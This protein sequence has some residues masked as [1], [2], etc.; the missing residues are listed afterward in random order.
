[1]RISANHLA[2]TI[3]AFSAGAIL[4]LT[5]LTVEVIE[6]N[7]EF[8]RKIRIIND[9]TTKISSISNA[10]S[11][12]SSAANS[13]YTRL[14]STSQKLLNNAQKK[15]SEEKWLRLSN[16]IKRAHTSLES[17]S[18]AYRSE[19]TS[20]Y[21][22]RLRTQT[23]LQIS[24]SLEQLQ[25]LST[26]L[27]S[28]NFIYK[29]LLLQ[30]VVTIS[31][32]LLLLLVIVSLFYLYGFVYPLRKASKLVHT[33]PLT[34]VVTS[35]LLIAEIADFISAIDDSKM[36]LVHL[37]NHDLLTGLPNRKAINEHLSRALYRDTRQDQ[38]SAVLFIDLD[39][40]KTI[41]DSLGHSI[42]DRVLQ[43]MGERLLKTLRHNDHLARIGGDEFTV[44]LDNIQTTENVARISQKLIK[45][46][47]EPIDID[48]HLISTRASIGI[49][50]FPDDGKTT[51]E[52]LRN[53]D[54]ALY[55]AK[56][57]GKGTYHFY[58]SEL[59]RIASKKLQ[60]EQEIKSALDEEQL[61][62]YFQPQVHMGT[63]EL[64]GLE[65]LVRWNHPERGL[66]T[67]DHFLPIA[68][69]SL[70]I[71]AIGNHVL[72]LACRQL[73]QWQAEN[74]SP[75][76]LAINLAS[77]QLAQENFV[78]LVYATLAKYG[79]DAHCIEL[80]I[81]E[82]SLLKHSNELLSDLQ[83]LRESGI[84]IALDDF[85]TG[86][87]SLSHLKNLP[88]DT[89]KIDRS[90][91]SNIIHDVADAT[92]VDA[93]IRLANGL[94]IAIVAEGVETLELAKHV[95]T[96]GCAIGQGYYYAKPMQAEQVALCIRKGKVATARCATSWV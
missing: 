67:P 40:F 14:F 76:R 96:T 45:L 21:A 52:L 62:L 32:I 90:F 72:D 11:L 66:L 43:A 73:S 25:Q 17:W 78:E 50:L 58:T 57:K 7:D 3:I 64:V 34:P 85:G 23:V 69:E 26:Q 19:P 88:V 6:A 37:S 5:L 22:L 83:S 4:W 51:E 87:S 33:Q 48:G 94:G 75:P 53:A 30:K 81:T 80:E 27:S 92:I 15:T 41:N 29:G 91:V 89:L 2:Y 36:Q 63:C 38:K 59:T 86:Y 84:Q 35:P 49:A 31:G 56:S 47:A 39:D 13:Y 54:A 8:Q 79:I 24:R 65:A 93:V 82:T 10:I 61:E 28:E 95:Y 1:M 20:E 60:I 44:H 18:Q 71:V 68:S 46:I 12:S 55:R 16:L 42:G 77:E 9:T 70:L 74:L